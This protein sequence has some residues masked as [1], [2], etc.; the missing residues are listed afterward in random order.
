VQLNA[1]LN[2]YDGFTVPLPVTELGMVQVSYLWPGTSDPR[3]GE[4]S[5]GVFDYGG[6]NCLLALADV[7][8]FAC[9]EIDDIYGNSI[10]DLCG[11]TVATDNVGMYGFSHPGI[12]AVRV[13]AEHGADLAGVDYLV[14]GEMPTEPAIIAKEFGYFD[15]ITPVLNP[16]YEYPTDY[17]A[18]TLDHNLTLLG[19]VQNAQYPEGRPGL[20]A[21]PDWFYMADV[22]PIMDGKRFYSPQLTAALYSNGQLT[23]ADWPADVANPLECLGT[24]YYRSTNGYNTLT[25]TTWNY[26]GDMAA[27]LP[28]L[29]VMLV[30]AERDHIQPLADKP[31][32]HQA[33]DGCCGNGLWTRLNPDRVYARQIDSAYD[34]PAFPDISANTGPMDWLQIEAG[35]YPNL[36]DGA[37]TKTNMSLAAVSEM[38]DRVQFSDWSAN[39]SAV[40]F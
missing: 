5:D 32:I 26:F 38:A 31:H 28:D 15:G 30:F 13:L 34:N 29:K 18:D 25:G 40:L 36:F 21:V 22:V 23:Q 12:A 11:F 4:A 20:A 35:G 9:G 6:E 16:Y 8:K 19:W 1:F 7:L 17:D 39:L 37:A 27:N 3:T 10:D 14:L 2:E 24:W 33:F